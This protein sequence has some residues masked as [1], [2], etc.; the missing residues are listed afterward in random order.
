MQI[1]IDVARRLGQIEVSVRNDLPALSDTPPQRRHGTG[2]A[3]R[4]IRQRL[5]LLY[6]IAAEVDQGEV[7]EEETARWRARLRLPL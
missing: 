4:N 7:V 2:T 6:D 1:D 5:H 3:L